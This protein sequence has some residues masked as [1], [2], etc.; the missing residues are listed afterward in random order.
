MVPCMA[1]TTGSGRCP[2]RYRPRRWL[3][4]LR[5]RPRPWAHPS[6]TSTDVMESRSGAVM[7]PIN[8]LRLYLMSR[9][10]NKEGVAGGL[11]RL[12]V[13]RAAFD[14]VVVTCPRSDVL[15]GTEG[16]SKPR[17][18]ARPLWKQYGGEGGAA[19]LRRL[20]VMAG[21]RSPSFDLIQARR[22]HPLPRRARRSS[23]GHFTR[24]SS[25]RSW[26]RR[27]SSGCSRPAAE[28]GRTA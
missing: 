22:A 18:E 17:P 14:V 13:D 11:K 25:L 16:P 10:R 23:A 19:R 27:P 21:W 28:G 20:Q 1:L 6:N 3:C 2:A 5:A 7:N 26:P 12:G 15:Q 9:M 8:A 24:G 4:C